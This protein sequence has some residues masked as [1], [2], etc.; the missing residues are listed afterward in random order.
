M[1]NPLAMG[2]PREIKPHFRLIGCE[3]G[4]YAWEISGLFSDTST[5][6][7]V[8]KDWFWSLVTVEKS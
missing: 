3:D 2:G 6:F 4:V 7:Y 1:K 8:R 5:P